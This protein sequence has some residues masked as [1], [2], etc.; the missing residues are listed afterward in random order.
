MA[1]DSIP[2]GER[3]DRDERRRLER[4]LPELIKRVI[5][6]G[7]EKLTEGP[8][9]LRHFVSEL[10]L[11]KDVLSLILSQVDETKNGLYRVVAKEIHDFLSQTN[12]ADELSKAL[13]TLSFEIKTEVRF[14]P[15]D[16][17]VGAP[18]RPDV[19]AKVRIKRDRD[20]RPGDDEPASEQEP[21]P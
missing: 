11:P 1:S 5:E 8:E 20:S 16:S 17:R 13:T 21:K 14:I 2:P 10:K 4:I 9:N 15:N 19:R 12:L 6:T 7:Y 18:P 3:E